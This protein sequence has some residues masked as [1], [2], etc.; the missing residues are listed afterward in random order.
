MESFIYDLVFN[1]YINLACLR[2][3]CLFVSNKRLNGLTDRAQI[4]CGISRDPREGSIF[5]NF[6]NPRIFFFENSRIFL[7]LL[8]VNKEN[9]CVFYFE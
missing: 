5:E 1:L 2:S 6:E 9:P 8:F 3:V 4:F 7:F